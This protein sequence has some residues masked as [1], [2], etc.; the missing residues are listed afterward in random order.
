MQSDLDGCKP[1]SILPLTIHMHCYVLRLF[2]F[3]YYIVLRENI[4]TNMQRSIPLRKG[5]HLSSPSLSLLILA[6]FTTSCQWEA[7]EISISGAIVTRGQL[8]Q[9]CDHIEQN[10]LSRCE[11]WNPIQ[12]YS[13]HHGNGTNYHNCSTIQHWLHISVML[14]TL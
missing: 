9:W 3:F 1:L 4:F 2:L 8:G 11:N 5:I 12:L 13:A 14:L 7:L 6:L 10:A